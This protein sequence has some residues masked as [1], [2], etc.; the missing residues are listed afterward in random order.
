M[1]RTLIA[2]FALLLAS[3][4]SATD[5]LLNKE[6]SQ[7]AF[8]G[9]LAGEKFV[10]Q[11]KRFSAEIRFDPAKLDEAA[12]VVTIDMSSAKIGDAQKD[13]ALPKREWF[14][15]KSHASARWASNDV[16]AIGKGRYAASGVLALKGAT[17]PVPVEFTL[18]IKDGKARAVGSALINR[19][20]FGVGSG[21][22]ATE[23][24]VAFPVKVTFN[25]EAAKAPP[26]KAIQ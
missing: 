8:E 25:I 3:E 14:D 15:V 6:K 24:W 13:A 5:W 18:K 20:E 22:F 7:I 16:R 4:A 2:A 1:V 26:K 23:E 12:I 10:G 21:S 17:K 19:S 9:S 11:F